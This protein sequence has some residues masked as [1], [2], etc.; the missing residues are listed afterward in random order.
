MRSDPVKDQYWCVHKSGQ[1]VNR[2]SSF[3]VYN[4]TRTTDWCEYERIQ[5][6]IFDHLLASV[7]VFDLHVFQEPTG[8]DFTGAFSQR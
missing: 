1:V 5:A 4:F 7:G 6:D 8:M 2:S 3:V